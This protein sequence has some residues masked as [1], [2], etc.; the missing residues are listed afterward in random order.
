[1]NKT[2]REL[3]RK[4]S[5]IILIFAIIALVLLAV[6]IT[7]FSVNSKN[8]DIFEDLYYQQPKEDVRTVLG[9]PT[10]SNASCDQYE[11]AKGFGEVGI[12]KA[13]FNDD[14]LLGVFFSRDYPFVQPGEE[15]E[16]NDRKHAQEYML[17]IMA[18]YTKKY[19]EPEKPSRGLY[20]WS[21][22]DG[23]EIWL[24][25][26]YESE[27]AVKRISLAWYPLGL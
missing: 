22:P 12:L 9:K 21:L 24:E 3:S 7:V 27:T 2:M 23:A 26:T 18:L 15:P 6:I 5:V 8:R 10:T 4:R 17:S 25:N 14:G 11:K 19:G 16:E 20:K 13:Y 1:M